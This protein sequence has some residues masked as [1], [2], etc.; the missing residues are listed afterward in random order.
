MKK[1]KKTS[2]VFFVFAPLLA[3]SQ[4]V[5]SQNAT[6]PATEAQ[7][8]ALA[9]KLIEV[10][11]VA[12]LT[13]INAANAEKYLSRPAAGKDEKETALLKQ[14]TGNAKSEFLVKKD[15]IVR[16]SLDQVAV[17]LAKKFSAAELQYLISIETYPTFNSYRK[18]LESDPYIN[19]SG[20]PMA[21]AK[22]LL[23]TQKSKLEK[24]QQKTK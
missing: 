17:E 15:R 19:A 16:E 12:D 8:L 11:N 24:A 1:N 7:K 6:P 18:F 20:K 23:K 2:L 9:K 13:Q 21:A 3:L 10:S 4:I 22:D 5:H 14:A